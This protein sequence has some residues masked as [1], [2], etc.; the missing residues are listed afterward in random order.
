[1]LQCMESILNEKDRYSYEYG[2]SRETVILILHSIVFWTYDEDK[3]N[4]E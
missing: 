2:N 4:E 3:K 1:M